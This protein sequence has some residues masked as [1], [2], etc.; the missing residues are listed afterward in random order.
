[1]ATPYRRLQQRCK[2]E[3]LPANRSQA[4]LIKL[5][6]AHSGHAT[7]SIGSNAGTS[8]GHTQHEHAHTDPE[9]GVAGLGTCIKFVVAG[10][11]AL[12]LVC[13]A[14][15]I[16][17][18]GTCCCL[19]TATHAGLAL[20]RPTHAALAQAHRGIVCNHALCMGQGWH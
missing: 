15:D 19:L 4:E 1:M 13:S 11:G 14:L 8:N 18:S 6:G 10:G 5:L 20:G 17:A 3:G 7:A 16:T 12:V 2:A 9:K